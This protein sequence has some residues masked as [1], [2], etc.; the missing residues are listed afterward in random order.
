MRFVGWAALLAVPLVFGCESPAA[1]HLVEGAQRF[2]P[3]PV[4]QLWWAMTQECSGSRGVLA[5]VRWYYVAGA[6]TLPVNG[7]QVQ[8]YWTSGNVIVLAEPAMLNG[9]LV[10]HEMLHSLQEGSGH[11]REF[12]LNRC[13]G[14]VVCEG[15]CVEDA[16]PLPPLDP[17]AVHVGPEALEIGVQTRPQTPSPTLYDGYFTVTVTARNPRSEPVIVTLPSTTFGEPATTFEYRV[18]TAAGGVAGSVQAWDASVT[19][20]TPGE[21]KRQV[22]DFHL[23]KPGS[24]AGGFGSGTYRF[25]GAFGGRWGTTA[26]AVTVP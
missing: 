21:T 23:Y 24:N 5:N 15:G 1:P 7:Q 2:E 14:V 17:A 3:P 4:Y 8:G 9:S 25:L 19:R 11:S 10:R 12:F 18:E 6:Q 26:A 20:F 13:A 22:F 16:E